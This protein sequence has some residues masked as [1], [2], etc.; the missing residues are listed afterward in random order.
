MRLN[1]GCGYNHE[2]VYVNVDKFAACKPDQ[3]VDLEQFPWPWEDNS[4]SEIKLFHVLEHLGQTPACFIRIMG[5]M[6]RVLEENGVV[7]ITVPH[8]RSDAYLGDP[9]HVRVITPGV[10]SLFSHKF[11]NKAIAEKSANSPL[12][13]YH[14]INF[15]IVSAQDVLNNEYTQKYNEALQTDDEYTKQ[16]ILTAAKER[17]NVLTETKIK[18]RKVKL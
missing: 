5:E 18:L 17:F 2:E 16:V 10:L 9:T 3:V 8:P 6:Y 13:I 15:D 11:L 7:D 4:V 1:L 12:G 14:G